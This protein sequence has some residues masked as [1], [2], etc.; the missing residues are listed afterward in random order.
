MRSLASPAAGTTS[1]KPTKP[2]IIVAKLS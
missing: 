1:A 2:W